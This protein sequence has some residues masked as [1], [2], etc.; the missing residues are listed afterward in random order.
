MSMEIK[1][2]ELNEELRML[3]IFTGVIENEIRDAGEREISVDFANTL[4]SMISMQS[5]KVKQLIEIAEKLEEKVKGI[6][7]D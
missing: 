1:I 6:N 2:S 4:L 5:A 7:N 3:E